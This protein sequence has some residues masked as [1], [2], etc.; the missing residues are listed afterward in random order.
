[1]KKQLIGL[2]VAALMFGGVANAGA[3]IVSG[4]W[5]ADISSYTFGGAAENIF[6]DVQQI[7]WTV[8]Y[9]DAS[10]TMTTFD[11]N[12]VITGTLSIS[13]YPTGTYGFFSDAAYYFDNNMTAFWNS[14]DTAVNRTDLF[15]WQYD[16]DDRN[17]I[18][19]Y[20][21]E[22]SQQFYGHTGGSINN[23]TSDGYLSFY[24]VDGTQQKVDL[25]NIEFTSSPVPEPATMLLFG[26]GLV[27]L[28]GSRIRK[29]KKQQ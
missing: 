1:M 6:Q 17:D 18:F 22:H 14:A 29:K 16:N 25:T 4:I 12:G 20:Y 13:D 26:A 7:S 9:D 15:S 3:A 28:V 5:T 21:G 2:G 27:G 23:P 19:N 8:T 11:P 10:T 24:A